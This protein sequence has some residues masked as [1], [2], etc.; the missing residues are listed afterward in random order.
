MP[1]RCLWRQ[2]PVRRYLALQRGDDRAGTQIRL[3]FCAEPRR[4]E[5]G[6]LRETYRCRAA[7]HSVCELEVGGPREG[8][9]GGGFLT[10]ENDNCRVGKAQRAHQIFHRK[11]WWARRSCAFAHPTKLA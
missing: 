7:G 10:N 11:K 1:R 9:S 6:A 8:I 5:A 3:W 2:A 4:L